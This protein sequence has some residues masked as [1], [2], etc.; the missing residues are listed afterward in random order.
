ML[1]GGAG[2][3]RESHLLSSSAAVNKAANESLVPKSDRLPQ[4]SSTVYR[5]ASCAEKFG[6]AGQVVATADSV[7][8]GLLKA[9]FARVL[10]AP[11]PHPV[12]P[13]T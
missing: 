9:K 1:W 12:H 2:T 7:Q 11:E 10:F 13:C 8:K 5:L 6:N 4:T 3:Q